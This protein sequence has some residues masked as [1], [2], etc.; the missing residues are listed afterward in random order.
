M[1]ILVV[2]IVTV[3]L[4]PFGM[5][6]YRSVFMVLWLDNMQKVSNMTRDGSLSK[7]NVKS[8]LESYEGK[9]R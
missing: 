9:I 7:A 6:L 2:N 1:Q 8:T 3:P 4:F 5:S